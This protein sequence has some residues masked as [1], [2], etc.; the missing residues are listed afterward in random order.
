MKKTFALLCAA[1]LL[2]TG[3]DG[4]E[5]S[6]SPAQ[7]T[8]ETSEPVITAEAPA[9]ESIE[10]PAGVQGGVSVEETADDTAEA[11]AEDIFT[12]LTYVF[13]EQHWCV[14]HEVTTGSIEAQVGY[15]TPVDVT[16]L[17]EFEYVQ[18]YLDY[19]EE[20]GMHEEKQQ[21]IDNN[22]YS[23]IR[24]SACYIGSEAADWLYGVNYYLS[25]DG[26]PAAAYY[27]KLIS[28]KDGI[29][30]D[31]IAEFTDCGMGI[32]TPIYHDEGIIIPT[33]TAVFSLDRET[34]TLT[35][36]FDTKLWCRTD[37]VEDGY[38]I[39]HDG[40]S[41]I[42]VYYTESGDIVTTDIYRG[43]QDGVACFFTEDSIIYHDLETDDLKRFD[44]QT[45]ECGF[46][47][48]TA[49]EEN[50]LIR[51]QRTVSD[52]EWSAY[53]NSKAIEVTNLETGETKLYS[54]AEMSMQYGVKYPKLICIDGGVLY[55]ADFNN[56]VY[57]L[58][59]F[60]LAADTVYM[61]RIFAAG[62]RHGGFVHDP[63]TDRMIF[64][65]YVDETAA[66]VTFLH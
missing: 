31:T 61:Q 58:S 38:I 20:A 3:C 17:E 2:M 19:L 41:R 4:A 51:E 28:V 62:Y 26:P 9:T 24:Y 25:V 36:L 5:E 6:N 43:L 15:D 12:P 55:M 7:Q 45:R 46:I 21:I 10:A 14:S 1:A 53:K 40:D 57:M 37:V 66:A 59:A 33:D 48:L 32:G 47:E 11:P 54:F 22:N 44:I 8:A 13:D 34:L 30:T 18:S 27:S 39:Y 49:D 60:D 63:L 56:D 50:A 23:Y 35:K 64:A 29:V 16:Q 65:S 52:D 42:K